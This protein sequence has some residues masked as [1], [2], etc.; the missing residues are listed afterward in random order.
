M[1]VKY[2]FTNT[3]DAPIDT[4]VAFPLPEIP[5]RRDDNTAYWRDPGSGLKFK[6]TVDGQPLALQ[7]VEQA[8]FNGRDISAQAVSPAFRSIASPRISTP[9]STVCRNPNATDSMADGFIRNDGVGDNPIWAGLWSLRTTLTRHQTFPAR[10]TIAVEHEY[11]PMVGGSVGGGLDPALRS[12]AESSRFFAEKRQ[13]YCIDNEWLASFDRKLKRI[14]EQGRS[15]LFRS[16]AGLRGQDRRELEG[17]DR[18]FSP[19]RRQGQAELAGE[20]LRRGREKNLRH[21]IRGATRELYADE[22]SQHPDYRLGALK[23]GS[24]RRV[25]GLE[26]ALPLPFVR[27]PPIPRREISFSRAGPTWASNAASSVCRMSANRPFST[28]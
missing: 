14:K 27:G 5:P 13:K 15:A 1:R 8:L 6:T 21:A 18:R 25:G 19:C 22:R 9:R 26:D 11:A 16:V 24:A 10:R 4:L 2:R 28:R 17:A 7:V 23:T 20:F 12:D 3:T